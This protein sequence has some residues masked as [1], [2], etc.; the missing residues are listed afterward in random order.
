MQIHP[1]GAFG[2]ADSWLE[3]N[4]AITGLGQMGEILRVGACCT[5]LN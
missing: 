3:G 1:I 2:S 5:V 4:T